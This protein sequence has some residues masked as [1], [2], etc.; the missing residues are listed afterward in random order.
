MHFMQAEDYDFI[1][2]RARAVRR[3]RLRA[4]LSALPL[5]LHTALR[6]A[7]GGASIPCAFPGGI[8]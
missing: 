7:S 6:Y 3:L 5:P 1:E 2:I 8:L 4:G